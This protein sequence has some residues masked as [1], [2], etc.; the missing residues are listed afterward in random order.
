MDRTCCVSSTQWCFDSAV[1]IALFLKGSGT[2]TVQELGANV[3]LAPWLYSNG[4]SFSAVASDV[5][6]AMIN[7]AVS[8]SNV[9]YKITGTVT[10]SN[11]QPLQRLLRAFD[12]ASGTMLVETTSLADGS[13]KLTTP[14][15]K[16]VSIVCYHDSSE[17]NNS[18]VKDDIVP[19]LDE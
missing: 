2:R 10:D 1:G 3:I 16:P 15:N 4:G 11:N 9:V 8:A 18:Q 12:K 7:W 13:Y 17:T 19:I 5:I 14:T 6:S